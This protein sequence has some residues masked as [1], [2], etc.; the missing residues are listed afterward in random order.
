MNK[1]IKYIT[2]FIVMCIFSI[3]TVIVSPLTTEAAT[4]FTAVSNG[5]SWTYSLLAGNAVDVRLASTVSGQLVVPSSLNGYPVTTVSGTHSTSSYTTMLG[6]YG[7]NITSVIFPDSLKEIG[8]CSLRSKS[9]ITYV[10]VP[11]GV[12]KIGYMTFANMDNLSSITLPSTLTTLGYGVFYDSGITSLTIPGGVTLW[13]DYYNKYY[14]DNESILSRLCIQCDNLT[15]VVIEDGVSIIPQYA[16]ASC[17]ALKSVSLPNTLTKIG[18]GAFNNSNYLSSIVIPPNVTTIN[19]LAFN[20][21]D[22]LAAIYFLNPYTSIYDNKQTIS[23]SAIIYGFS[24]STAEAYSTAY[25]RT[26]VSI[27]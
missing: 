20:L 22:G 26:F 4:R 17:H 2:M 15:N 19:K 8:D 12:T 14:S 11:E 24:G 10:Y 7:A 16:F 13:G 25:S 21:C 23:T 1:F 9:K 6:S 3:S 5:V 27:D 18:D